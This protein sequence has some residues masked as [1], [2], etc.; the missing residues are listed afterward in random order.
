[1]PPT[2]KSDQLTGIAAKITAFRASDTDLG[3]S[4]AVKKVR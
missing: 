2:P 3:L 4:A 1:M